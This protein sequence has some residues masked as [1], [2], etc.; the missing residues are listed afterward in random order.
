M[1]TISYGSITIVDITDV[2]EFSV[3]PQANKA[4]TQIYNPDQ[5]G[6]SAYTPNWAAD[7]NPL[8]I[9]PVAF[10]AGT[11]ISNIA[12]YSWTKYVNGVATVLTNHETVTG[13]RNETLTIDANILTLASPIV[14]YQVTASYQNLEE[15]GNTSLT[16]TGRI[17]FA[18]V[19]QGGSMPFVRIVGENIFAYDTAGTLKATSSDPIILT[20]SY[21]HIT[22][23]DWY[24]KTGSNPE[25]WTRYPNAYNTNTTKTTGNNP[26]LKVYAQ[27]TDDGTLSG[28]LIFENDR[29]TIKYKGTDVN[30]VEI[31][32]KFTITKLRDG[33]MIASAVLTNDNQMIPANKDGIAPSSAFGEAT[34][35]HIVIYD[36]HGNL[37]TSN[38]NI[39]IAGTTGIEYK[40]SKNGTNWYDPDNTDLAYTYVKVTNMGNAV[41][42][43]NITFT[44][45]H[46]TDQTAAPIQKTFSLIK[47]NAGQDGADPEIYDIKSDVIAV[48][49]AKN[50][51]GS[52][53]AYTPA[54]ITFTAYKT[55]GDTTT[56]YTDGFIQVF[57]DTGSGFSP[58]PTDTST[59][60]RGTVSYN[61]ATKS[62]GAKVIKAVLYKENTF[63]TELASQ[64]VIITNDGA[65]GSDGQSGLGAINVIIDNEHD[66]II[67]AS[68]N[69]TTA[70]QILTISYTG[71][72]GTT[73]RD[74]TISVPTLSG[75]INSQGGADTITGTVTHT[76][77]SASGSISFTIPNGTVLNTNGQA[78]LSFNVLGQHYNNSGILVDD[79][80]RTIINKLFTWTRSAAP[81]DAIVV[82][83]EYPNGQVY[84]NTTGTLTVKAIVSDGGVPITLSDASYV[85]T[86]YD[87]TISGD[88]KYGPLKGSASVSGNTLTVPANAVDS[89]ASFRVVVTYPNN[90]TTTYKAFASLI[91]KFDPLQIS[92]HSTI[93]QQIKN[94]IGFG[95]LFV[96]VRQNNDEIDEI[97]LNIEAVKQTSEVDVNATYCILCVQP[98]NKMGTADTVTDRGSAIL[99]KKTNGTWNAV[100]DYD[101]TYTWTYHDKDGNALGS[102]DRKPATSGKC[103]YIDGSLINSKITADVTVTKN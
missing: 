62:V 74:T 87:G 42:T 50:E 97:P 88:D 94:G 89:F 11:N 6:V 14:T 65:K 34:T 90:G 33:G 19:S 81:A 59:T 100:S 102:G 23:D 93:G 22:A 47:I 39:T 4:Q 61:I 15:F 66:G 56:T 29:L 80:N 53:G 43:G 64:S 51:D 63:T 41:S 32:D 75:F 40:V 8:V 20:A 78:Q 1:A 103:I 44:C 28:N 21:G 48:N 24:Y 38:W 36:E 46:K 98:T 57:A 67:C 25:T 68:N 3:Y 71:Y 99:Y 70:D 26:T 55:V 30:G 77:G 91:D 5:S 79:S 9:T 83:M 96:K 27:Q 16:A 31:Y 60:A 86:Q 84:Q 95:A 52:G 72:Q 69:K 49:R 101:C 73:A 85:W 17:D 76:A 92:V 18:L 35:T 37:D 54:S 2:G 12:T 58:T 10:Y 7:Q 82:Y 45:N 13:Q